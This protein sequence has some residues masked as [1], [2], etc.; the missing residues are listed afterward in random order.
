MGAVLILGLWF[1]EYDAPCGTKIIQEVS[2]PD[3][4]YIA[5]LFVK[6]CGATTSE[7]T[8]LNIRTISSK[9]NTD[10]EDIFIAQL[11][12][13]SANVSWLSSNIL[14]VDVPETARIFKN[15][16]SFKGCQIKYSRK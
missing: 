15:L 14:L 8:H 7:S 2:S 4:K 10:D 16:D 3:K 9:L 1:S 11:G 6:D 12:D 5:T 13:E